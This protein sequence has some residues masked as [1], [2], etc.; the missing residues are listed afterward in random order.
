MTTATHKPLTLPAT[1]IGKKALLG[2]SGVVLFGFVII[3]MLANLQVFLGPEA[4]NAYAESVKSNAAILWGARSVLL[5]ALVVHV[6]LVVQLYVRSLRA[7]PVRYRI[8][9]NIATTYAASAMKYSGPALLLYV[10]FHLIHFTYPGLSIGAKA[11]SALDVYGN[12]VSSFQVPWVVALY[13]TANLL[14]G[15]HLFHGGYSMLQ[16]LGVNHPRYNQ[17]ARR[18]ALAFSVLVT[19]GNVFMPLAVF[20]GIVPQ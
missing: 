9:K 19:A 18:G 2:V 7:R 1:S 13:V 14:L 11:W 10:V 3:H 17:R 8:K 5:V 4:Y 12:F 16:S 20:L 6:A 15:L